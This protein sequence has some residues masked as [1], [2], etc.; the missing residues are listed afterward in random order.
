MTMSF[1]LV[2]FAI[3]SFAFGTWGRRHAATLVSP[4]L[5]DHGRHVR[6]KSLRRGSTAF[7]ITGVLWF[8]LAVVHVIMYY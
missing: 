7:R 8:L 4:S 2:L 3:V 5:S 1:L 6:E